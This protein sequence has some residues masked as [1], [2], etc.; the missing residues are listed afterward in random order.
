MT[1][2][3]PCL[4]KQPTILTALEETLCV[5]VCVCV[6]V[7]TALEETVCVCVCVCVCVRALSHFSRI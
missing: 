6:C 2:D 1:I 7:L 3:L 5:C 4:Q